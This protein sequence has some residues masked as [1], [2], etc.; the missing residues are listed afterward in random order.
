MTTSPPDP[1][2]AG[3]SGRIE[4][5]LRDAYDGVPDYIYDPWLLEDHPLRS[6]PTEC[7]P[8]LFD[9]IRNHYRAARKNW[10]ERV[11]GLVCFLLM[12]LYVVV[13]FQVR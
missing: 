3:V 12:L 1:P 13:P 4:T 7:C 10:G 5:P 6:Y 9:F 8:G 2:P 11:F